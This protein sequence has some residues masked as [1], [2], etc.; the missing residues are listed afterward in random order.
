MKARQTRSSR[1][2]DPALIYL[3]SF[4]RVSVK[5]E[6]LIDR[7]AA[8]ETADVILDFSTASAA[9]ALA[10]LSGSDSNHDFRGQGTFG[11][12]KLSRNQ[13]GIP[14]RSAG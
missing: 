14:K 13:M 3:G 5:A 2:A 4:G 9:A 7:V 10:A 12:H 11:R 6:G 8:P 1:A